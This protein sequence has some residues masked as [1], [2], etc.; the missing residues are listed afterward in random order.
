M[1]WAASEMSCEVCTPRRRD[2]ALRLASNPKRR[3]S[4]LCSFYSLVETCKLVDVP[5][6]EYL[7]EAARRAIAEPGTITLPNHYKAQR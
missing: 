1:T 4:R 7:A 6:A 2:Q 3:S 5:A